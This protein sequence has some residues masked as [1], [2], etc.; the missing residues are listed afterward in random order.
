MVNIFI[1]GKDNKVPEYG[2]L[3][4][5]IK[6]IGIQDEK[7]KIIPVNGYKNLLSSKTSGTNISLMRANVDAGKKNLVIFDA[8]SHDNNGGF[9]VRR[10]ELI[11]NRDSAGVDFELFLWPDNKSDGDVECLMERI[12]RKDLYPEFFSCFSKY[13]CCISK[14]KKDNGEQFYTSP[15]RKSKIYTY[16]NSLP[17]SNTKKR[18]SGKGD[19]GWGNPEIWNFDAM[20][21][22]PIKNF[23]S[24]HING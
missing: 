11:N 16:F 5:I 15:D 1:E 10:E 2:F 19:W 17:I 14:R 18:N 8:D 20:E 9:A 12:A 4:A 24:T 21:L 13:E 6:N 23:L 22:Q 3:K 7:Y